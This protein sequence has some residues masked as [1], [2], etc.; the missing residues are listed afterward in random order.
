[1]PVL[2]EKIGDQ[3]VRLT[4][5]TAR[6]NIYNTAVVQILHEAYIGANSRYI[7][8]RTENEYVVQDYSSKIIARHVIHAGYVEMNEYYCVIAADNKIVYYS[9]EDCIWSVLP[10]AAP[11]INLAE[12]HILTFVSDITNKYT[13][14][15]LKS[16]NVIKAVPFKSCPEAKMFPFINVC[17]A[18]QSNCPNCL[19]AVWPKYIGGKSHIF[20]TKDPDTNEIRIYSTVLSTVSLLLTTHGEFDLGAL[21]CGFIKI[22]ADAIIHKD[23]LDILIKTETAGLY[24]VKK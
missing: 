18:P 5:Y 2:C 9:F 14:V 16:E 1:M 6:G 4:V 12:D 15:D 19:K 24:I 22:G 17:S 21:N 13:V 8:R 23:G 3:H 20:Y 11:A 7:C 10:H